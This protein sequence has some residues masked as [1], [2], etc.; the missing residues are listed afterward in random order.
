MKLF[1]RFCLR[2]VFAL[3]ASASF[4]FATSAD[5]VVKVPVARV[6]LYPG[7]VIT[8][9][10]LHMR[11]YYKRHADRLAIVR[12]RQKIVGLVAKRTLLAGR[13][14][15]INAFRRAHAVTRGAVVPV[16]L[17]SSG[18]TITAYA[19]PLQ[20]GAAGDIIQ[21]RNVDTGQLITARVLADGGL[22]VDL[23]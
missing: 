18:L 5:Q 10:N 3:F 15:P 8:L 9:Q 23:K 13:P 16:T 1:S 11:A 4:A 19:R 6:T 20:S 17:Q 7:D 14:I 21:A 22:L 2:F 12:D